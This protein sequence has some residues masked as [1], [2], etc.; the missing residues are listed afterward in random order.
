VK[1]ISQ[2]LDKLVSVIE[3]RAQQ[4]K[5]KDSRQLGVGQN[6]DQGASRYQER[7][8]DFLK[9][10]VDAAIGRDRVG[11]ETALRTLVSQVD[12]YRAGSWQPL[13]DNLMAF[14][15]IWGITQPQMSRQWMSGSLDRGNWEV[16]RRNSDLSGQQ[17][18][19]ATCN[20]F[21]GWS[22]EGTIGTRGRSSVEHVLWSVWRV[23]EY[24]DIAEAVVE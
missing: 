2:K 11:F 10:E 13:E 20:E 15:D 9:S 4:T 14:K 18:F 22:N 1:E 5:E 12:Q 24:M 21:T 16:R 7:V 19:F 17:R 6:V 3:A 8:G 23:M